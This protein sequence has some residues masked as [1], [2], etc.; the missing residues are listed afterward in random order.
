MINNGTTV[1]FVSHSLKQVEDI[2]TRVLWLEGGKIKEIGPT[3][4]V[5]NK[6]KST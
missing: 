1:L 3:K 6:Y 5:C 2:C 4:E